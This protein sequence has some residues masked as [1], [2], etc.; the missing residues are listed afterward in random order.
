[1]G[2][3]RKAAGV[4]VALA[5]SVFGMVV[6]SSA[7]A[8]TSGGTSQ[9][10]SGSD[11]GS[12]AVWYSVQDSSGNAWNNFL[13]IAQ[14]ASLGSQWNPGT[15]AGN[16]P[17]FLD[18]SVCQ[19]S[20]VIWWLGADGGS[21]HPEQWDPYVTISYSGGAAR[22][23]T[24]QGGAGNSLQN[25]INTGGSQA[26]VSNMY[27]SYANWF[28]NG[29]AQDYTVV[30]SGGFE[31]QAVA[32]PSRNLQVGSNTSTSTYAKPYSWGTQVTPQYTVDSA[33]YPMD[34]Q[35]STTEGNF[36][37]LWDRIRQ[38]PTSESPGNLTNDVNT[39]VSQ[40]S[41]L[42]HANVQLDAKNSAAMTKRGGVLNVSEYTTTA[43]ITATETDTTYQPQSCIQMQQIGSNGTWVNVGGPQ[44]T[45]SAAAYTVTSVSD[46]TTMQTQQNTGFYQV[47]QTICNNDG[48]L[49]AVKSDLS[50]KGALDTSHSSTKT[51][52]GG[53]V[54]DVVQTT[55]VPQRPS[56]V[57]LGDS[58]NSDAV[59][60][61]SGTSGF[62][63][64][65]C[66]PVTCT[67]A[68]TGSGST[69]ANGATSNVN[70]SGTTPAGALFGATHVE[71]GTTT[72]SN[73][74][75]FFR[76]NTPNTITMDVAYPVS[77]DNVS[78]S[79]VAPLGTMVFRGGTPGV[80]AAGSNGANF[81]MKTV[82]G[83][84]LFSSTTKA[85]NGST[86]PDVFEGSTVPA[87]GYSSSDAAVLSGLQRTFTVQSNW[88]SDSNS[89]E[90]VSVMWVY[91]VSVTETT[92]TS[93]GF[94]PTGGSVA[95][96]VGSTTTTTTA[97]V[98]CG[99][100]YGTTSPT[101]TGATSY[102]GTSGN[103]EQIQQN[104]VK[105]VQG[106]DKDGALSINFVRAAGN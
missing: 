18:V 11:G 24:G 88:A 94:V 28:N 106:D 8:D 92:D 13:N 39:A 46:T 5:L 104:M 40:D 69:T 65:Q 97:N 58:G 84:S 59:L 7:V 95:S 82:S 81:T 62:Y 83:S 105:N 86:I 17:A 60:A 87:N 89:P 44:Y 43:T 6:P 72:N 31:Q 64:Q 55:T 77:G 54:S 10:G 30:C 76:D 22:V 41:T 26:A 57:L 73:M 15:S 16:N 90:L 2:V 47:M 100:V 52:N 93:V 79:G 25:A 14:T 20:S 21:K 103:L 32:C 27:N 37:R 91:P 9:G 33:A 1:M 38:N 35:S 67:T 36:G 45:N 74:F 12:G 102:T 63:T 49:T 48:T 68:S 4:A 70:S 98:T 34:S 50:S 78:Y 66:T 101:T 29:H 23:I 80:A 61:K 53:D 96:A 42:A 99:G 85:P 56:Q 75:T 71:S 51:T 19:R 3:L